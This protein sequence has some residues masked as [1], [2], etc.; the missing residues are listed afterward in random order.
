MLLSCGLGHPD[1]AMNSP[2]S[3]IHSPVPQPTPEAGAPSSGGIRRRA[4]LV[5][6]DDY[7]AS[8][9]R[10]PA[11]AKPDAGRQVP[12][13][14]GAINDVAVMRE[15]L[16]LL[17][18]FAPAD[19]VTLTDQQATR[20]RILETL[21]QKLMKTAAPGDV[22]LVYFGGHGSQ[23]KNSGSDEPDGMDE[24]LIP[25]DSRLGADDITDK[26]LRRRFNAI[27]DQGA[28]LT[29]V[30]DSCHSG[31]GARGLD[32]GAK[33]R[34]IKA[35]L[36]D[37]AD[38][39]A[40]GPR[41]EARGALVLSAAQDFNLAYETV[42][43]DRQKHGAFSWAL[44]R[45]MR[46]AE[47]G[48]P[49]SELF[50]RAQARLRGETPNQ[51][52]AIAGGA[53]ARQAPLL[54]DRT[55]PPEER[56]VVAVESVQGDGKVILQGGWAHGL[57]VG[58][59]LDLAGPVGRSVRLE[60][61]A[62]RGLGRCEARLLG[63]GVRK[64]GP[65]KSLPELKSGALAVVSGWASPPGPALRVWIPRSSGDS[66]GVAAW[67]R[68]LERSAVRAGVQWN[69]DPTK[70]TPTHL[71]RWH[72]EEWELL[73]LGRSPERLGATPPVSSVLARIPVGSSLFVQ[74]PI[75]T[76]LV[77]D[78]A[79][80][81]ISEHNGVELTERP[82]EA[83]YILVGRL[84]KDQVEYA[85]VRPLVGAADLGRS[86]LPPRTEWSPAET[87]VASTRRYRE[88]APDLESAVFR[89]RKIHAWQNLSAPARAQPLYRLTVRRA[90]DGRPVEDGVLT[91]GEDYG[92]VLRAPREQPLAPAPSR[93][94]YAFAIDSFG[95]SV[96]L[97]P[98][99]I[100]SIENC[101]PLPCRPGLSHGNL[102]REIPFGQPASFQVREPFGFDTYFLLATD[103]PLSNPWILEWD[104]VRTRGP[105]GK[106]ALEELLSV[107]G[108]T[109]RSPERIVVPANWSIE[110]VLFEARPAT[111]GNAR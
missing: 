105:A 40:A 17:Y 94:F 21:E 66:R 16:V 96:L 25:A 34:G 29:V 86:G 8:Q 31:S 1:P 68:D 56:T 99:D 7:S 104:G 63:Q 106:T 28:R 44:A 61:T 11:G 95:R 5:G 12:N 46:D 82:E 45:A 20:Q 64:A 74:L 42:G 30:L 47:R 36:R 107:T 13:L 19:I 14:E 93:Y 22:V 81:A 103:E 100:G 41:P 88:P 77:Q 70:A 23:R 27:L 51:N 73:A 108:G 9:L 43:D 101:F 59:Q 91:A 67:A 71:L 97:H 54:G 37:L 89:L 2:K 109:R 60:V 26:E 35:D 102:P 92:M 4:L 52:P 69:D 110:K 55:G 49:A 38:G 32:S 58:S 6:I 65:V 3:M 48:E 57:T 24:T 80:G 78:L 53:E 33:P 10:P 98:T 39:S 83:D 15:L 76:G 111:A 18:G 84:A 79:K 72:G 75:P 50:L 85:W 87:T 62:L 90:S